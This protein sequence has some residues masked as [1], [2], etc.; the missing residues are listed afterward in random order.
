MAWVKDGVI[1]MMTK[2]V[3][4]VVFVKYRNLYEMSSQEL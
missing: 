3:V 2:D 1:R 4:D